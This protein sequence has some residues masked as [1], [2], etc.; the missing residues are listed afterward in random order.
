MDV[1]TDVKAKVKA[2]SSKVTCAR[3]IR[4]WL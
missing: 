1:A 4:T 2:D 3:N